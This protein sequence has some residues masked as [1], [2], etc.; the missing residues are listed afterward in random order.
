MPKPIEWSARRHYV[1]LKSRYTLSDLVQEGHLVAL[2]CRKSFD[3][4]KGKF[5]SYLSRALENHFLQLETDLRRKGRNTP[6]VGLDLV[7]DRLTTDGG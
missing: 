4:S 7:K 5:E 2:S 1:R 6:M 3:P